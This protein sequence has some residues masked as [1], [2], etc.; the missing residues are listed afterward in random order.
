MAND[1]FFLFLGTHENFQSTDPFVRTI[2]EGL[3]PNRLSKGFVRTIVDGL[4]SNDCRWTLFERLSMDFVRT[5]VDGLCPNV[6][7]R[8]HQELLNCLSIFKNVN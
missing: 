7:D 8:Q 3:C 1:L 6:V 5:I 4:C 2:V